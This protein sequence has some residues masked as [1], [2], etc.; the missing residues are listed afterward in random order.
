MQPNPYRRASMAAQQPARAS[1]ELR[2]APLSPRYR[3]NYT[4]PKAKTLISL[5]LPALTF[6]AP[7]LGRATFTT[8]V[9]FACWELNSYLKFITVHC[10]MCVPNWE[11]ELWLGLH[12]KQKRFPAEWKSICTCPRKTR[13]EISSRGYLKG[14]P[15]IGRSSRGVGF[16]NVIVGS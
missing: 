2:K 10:C 14:R 7:A 15:E 4:T 9:S 8:K 13:A 1:P 6:C 3:R 11:R 12:Q 16:R 5:L